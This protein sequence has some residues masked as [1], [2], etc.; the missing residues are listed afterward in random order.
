MQSRFIFILLLVPCWC[1]AQITTPGVPPSFQ[2]ENVGAFSKKTPVPVL[3]PSL[4]V[5]QAFQEDSQNPG[6]TRFAAPLAAD[7]APGQ[8]GVWADLPN[9]DRV[10]RC[11]V[12]APKALGLLLMFDRFQL[13]E[14]GRFFAYSPDH[15]QVF[16]AY[17][18][19]SCI[20]SGKF[21]IGVLPG[22]TAWIEYFEPASAKGQ[23]Q[24]HLDR[25]D[26]AY[27]PTALH[28]PTEAEN[29]GQS[30][31]CNVNVNCSAGADWQVTKKGV[32]RIL[33]KFSN[34]SAW[35]SG[36]LVANTATTAVPYFLTAHHCQ[37]IINGATPDFTLWRF[38]FDYES[39][40][41]TNPVTEPARK[42]VLGCERIAFREETDFLLLKLSPIPGSYGLYFNGWNRD[43][44]TSGVTKSTFIHH[45]SGDIKK[46]STDNQALVVHNLLINWGLQFGTS[47]AGT[48]WSAIPDA[49]IFQPGS[50]GCPLFDQNKRIVGQLHG[51]IINNA[52]NC[53]INA[54]YF[55]RFNLSWNAGA[56]SASRLSDWL[57]PANAGATTQNGYE[58]PATYRISGTLTT[59]SGTPMPGCKVSLTGSGTATTYSDA[60]GN[61]EFKNVV[62]GFTYTITPSRD[63]IP[64]NGVSTYDLVLVSK[65]ILGLQ[66][67]DTPWK[68]LAADANRS[69]SIT[70][71]DIV[72]TRKLILGI[73]TNLPAAAAWRF[74]P[75]S[76]VFSTPTNPFDVGT[77]LKDFI[78]ISNLQA[79]F[80][81]GHFKA[82]K[83]GDTDNSA[84]P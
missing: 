56:T 59:Y 39:A 16:G 6:Q 63:T 7:I 19:A 12:T 57:D 31:A 68:L 62:S 2:P 1:F 53:I 55:G 46:I 21:M 74:L 52:N 37:I 3:L 25:V 81:T 82:V 44:S 9:G 45:P 11:V 73:Y 8:N 75:A 32:A 50:S 5:S 28:A 35:C 65:H 22:E 15:Q 58:Q 33:M 26:Y 72:E 4:N 61:Y 20:P 80:T 38:D 41:C 69:G 51:G 18:K 29:F 77:V 36:S 17:T 47:A 30:L 71:F 10:W 79:D 83:V 78:T 84:T 60:Q 70:T 66:P 13:P 27:D 76:T 49:G 48:H 14:G 64:L 34:G 54:A 43:A 24:I 23:G 42:S 40:D 67:F